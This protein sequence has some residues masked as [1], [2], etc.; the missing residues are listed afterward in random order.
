MEHNPFISYE[1]G[2][3]ITYS[4]LKKHDNGKEYITIYFEEPNPDHDGFCSA[5]FDFPGNDFKNV[6]GYQPDDLQRLMSHIKQSA[7]T[8]FD[9]SREDAY[10]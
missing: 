7:Q 3:E 9:F 2:L 4:D 10:A 8:A 5:Q 1:D 6:R